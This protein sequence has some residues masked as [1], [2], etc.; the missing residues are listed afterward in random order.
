M[1]TPVPLLGEAP[2][3]EISGHEAGRMWVDGVPLPHGTGRSDQFSW[4]HIRRSADGAWVVRMK[5]T[6]EGE[7]SARSDAANRDYE[8]LASLGLRVLNRLT[9]PSVL[10][11]RIFTIS[12][13][14]PDMKPC[15]EE[16][17]W[18]VLPILRAFDEETRSERGSGGLVLNPY[19]LMDV[20]QHS[21]VDN[22][23]LPF[24]HDVDASFANHL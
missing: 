17:Y 23:E 2:R 8:R 9:V 10:D 5:E 21:W 6:P 3:L 19:E 24:L 18:S 11:R 1:P 12:P 16:E 20:D 13:W 4:R 14:V 15:P 7:A 22:P